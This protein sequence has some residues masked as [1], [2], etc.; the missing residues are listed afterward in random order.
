M[1]FNY[2][3]VPSHRNS[4]IRSSQIIVGLFTALI[5]LLTGDFSGAWE[6]IKTTVTNVLDT[7]WQYMQ[8]VW[9]SI[10]GFLTGVMNRTLSMFGTSWSEYGVQSL[11]LLAVFGTVL[12]VGLV[13]LLRVWPKNGTSTKLYYH[14]RF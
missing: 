4:D 12:Q 2:N 11:I 6:T 10:I 13:V 9:E 1:D 3:C 14:K 5:Q 8:S 7:I